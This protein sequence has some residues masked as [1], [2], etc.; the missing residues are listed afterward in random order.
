MKNKQRIASALLGV[1]ILSP[2]IAFAASQPY[3]LLNTYNGLPG[4]HADISGYGFGGNENVTLTLGSSQTTTHTDANGNFSGAPL[5][6]PTTAPGMT[7][8]HAHGAM[9]GTDATADFYIAGYYPHATPSSWYPF[10]GQTLSWSGWGF[11]PNET[12]TLTSGRGVLGSFSTNGGGSFGDQARMTVPYNYQNTSTTYTLT[13]SISGVSQMV[14][15]T[16]GTFYA[17]IDPSSY[18]VVKGATLDASLRNFAPNEQVDVMVNGVSV[19]QK[20]VD[21][22][23]NGVMRITAPGAGQTFTLSARGISSGVTSS[24]TIT[25]AQ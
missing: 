10:P 14:T 8:I 21:G 23:G 6:I 19:G 1:S 16:F 20:T 22:G 24:R 11:A 2:F 25:L 18:Y 15:I 5:T 12:V 17:N 9:S 4:T 3:L 13:G 7:L